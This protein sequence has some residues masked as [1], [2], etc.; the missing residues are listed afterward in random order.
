MKGFFVFLMLCV[1][2][3]CAWSQKTD[4][5]QWD[6]LM[7]GSNSN[8]T[9]PSFVR[10]RTRGDF[11]NYWAKLGLGAAPSDVNFNTQE[12]VAIHLDPKSNASK[13]Y[14]EVLDIEANQLCVRYATVGSN[15]RG[16]EHSS[17]HSSSGSPYTIIRLDRWAGSL[18]YIGRTASSPY[19]GVIVGCG[20]TRCHGTC[21]HRCGCRYTTFP[22]VLD[23]NI[24]AT[25]SYCPYPNQQ[26][27]V[28]YEASNFEQYWY[29]ILGNDRKSKM[30][31]IDWN[32]EMVIALHLGN[33]VSGGY[34]MKVS[35]IELLG[36][37]QINVTFAEITPDRGFQS[38]AMTQPYML[39]RVPRFA[40]VLSTRRV[41]ANTSIRVR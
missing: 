21:N 24:V 8:V 33:R 39:I 14:V 31:S 34:S 28:I 7:S 25:G 2:T 36:P 1:C 41:G 12:V 22:L 40:A 10:I 38:S 19:S 11:I 5:V 15:G 17:K 20:C 35:E 23:W 9:G 16:G 27:C 18:K 13:V 3:L 30:P 29:Q 32:N 4:A 37:S 6:V 26:S